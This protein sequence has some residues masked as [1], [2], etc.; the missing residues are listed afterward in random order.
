MD[1]VCWVLI[2]RPDL[3]W[4]KQGGEYCSA[5]G[6][7]QLVNK[8]RRNPDDYTLRGFANLRI[9]EISL[10]PHTLQSYVRVVREFGASA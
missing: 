1:S 8:I 9:V 7:M 10:D 3:T 2:Q 6:A 4:Y 5:R